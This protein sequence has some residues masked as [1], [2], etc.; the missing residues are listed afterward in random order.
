MK[1]SS[2]ESTVQSAQSTKKKLLLLGLVGH[3]TLAVLA[4]VTACSSQRTGAAA[5]S[6]ANVAQEYAVCVVYH[7]ECPGFAGDYNS[8]A[9]NAGQAHSDQTPACKAW[10]DST[11]KLTECKASST[12]CKCGGA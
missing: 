2:W 12:T 4:G 11:G 7:C 5:E 1:S 8:C 10:E 9:A 3:S 6:T